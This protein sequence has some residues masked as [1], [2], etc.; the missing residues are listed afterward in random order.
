MNLTIGF[1]QCAWKEW[2]QNKD[3]LDL[4][5]RFKN[6]TGTSFKEKKMHN[7]NLGGSNFFLS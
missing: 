3:K 2:K 7:S 5:T 1:L 6:K 4:V